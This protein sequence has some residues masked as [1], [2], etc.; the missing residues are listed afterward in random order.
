MVGAATESAI[1]NDRSSTPRPA[2]SPRARRPKRSKAPAVSLAMPLL[3]RE[4][5][6][7]GLQRAVEHLKAHRADLI[8]DGFI[9]DYV[10]LDWLEWHGGS[11]RL[12]VVGGNVCRQVALR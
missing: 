9:A 7:E 10:A 6:R 5:L 11:L 3:R 1:A 2:S 12:T 8:G 4:A